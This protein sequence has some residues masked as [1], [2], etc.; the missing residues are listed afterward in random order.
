MNDALST[1]MLEGLDDIEA[2]RAAR[3]AYETDESIRA[4]FGEVET[5]V[6]YAKAVARG[7]VRIAGIPR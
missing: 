7:R 3:E 5:A 1:A 2:E 6:H 4:E